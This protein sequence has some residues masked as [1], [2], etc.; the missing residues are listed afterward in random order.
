MTCKESSADLGGLLL[1]L[2]GVEERLQLVLGRPGPDKMELLAAQEWNVPGQSVRFLATGM[3]QTLKLFGVG[4]GSISRIACVHGPG[5]F[6]GLRLSLAFAAGISA[7][8][9]QLLAGLDYLPILAAGPAPLLKGTL[10]V[11][12]HSRRRQVYIQSFNCPQGQPLSPLDAVSLDAARESIVQAEGP[13]SLLGS[14]LRN[15]L[16]FFSGL[17][18]ERADISMLGPEWN[19]TRPELLLKAAEKAQFSLDPIVPRY[20]RESDAEANLDQIAA[21]RGLDPEAARRILDQSR[22]K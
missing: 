21:K 3:E 17:A 12:T 18:Q 6:T 16:D 9:G 22:E 11:L 5:S 20:L 2:N 15:N 4:V 1:C 19:R 14:G 7:G 10:V 8:R 13:V